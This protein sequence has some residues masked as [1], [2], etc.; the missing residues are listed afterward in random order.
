MKYIKILLL[1]LVFASGS[2]ALLMLTGLE[3]AYYRIFKNDEI[4]K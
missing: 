3:L 1:F 2:L 4:S